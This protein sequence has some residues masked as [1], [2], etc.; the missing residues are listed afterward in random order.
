MKLKEL[1]YILGSDNRAII[2]DAATN[3]TLEYGCFMWYAFYQYG[4]C[5]VCRITSYY[6][7]AYYIHCFVI[8]IER[9]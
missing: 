1:K 7:P 3:K 5:E 9:S 8:R 2:C 4:D 6:D